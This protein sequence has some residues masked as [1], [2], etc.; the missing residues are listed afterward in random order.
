VR[1]ITSWEKERKRE[2]ASLSDH[3]LQGWETMQVVPRNGLAEE[4]SL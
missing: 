4:R 3:P 1:N 2:E